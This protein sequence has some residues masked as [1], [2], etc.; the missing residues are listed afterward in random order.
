M[1]RI[2]RK[3]DLL[4]CVSRPG[5]HFNYRVNTFHSNVRVQCAGQTILL[6]QTPL[7]T[8]IHEAYESCHCPYGR[9]RIPNVSLS[10][11][12]VFLT[13]QRIIVGSF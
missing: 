7:I 3:L 10:Y 11:T 2:L 5:P 12:Q 8:D 6:P 9:P 1:M 4:I 13:M